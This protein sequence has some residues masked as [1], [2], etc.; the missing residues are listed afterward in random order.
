MWVINP[1]RSVIEKR[2]PP[3]FIPVLN[4]KNSQI[5]ECAHI[6]SLT[7]RA[8]RQSSARKYLPSLD[9]YYNSTATC[10]SYHKTR[11]ATTAHP[12][13]TGGDYTRC[14]RK[15]RRHFC[16]NETRRLT[17]PS[18]YRPSKKQ[19]NYYTMVTLWLHCYPKVVHYVYTMVKKLQGHSSKCLFGVLGPLT[20]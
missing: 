11:P 3:F 18:H 15:T 17:L 10:L 5:G 19:G 16:P 4:K 1:V 6:K 14:A 20:R 7:T 12:D 2:H 9:R 8:I 13:K